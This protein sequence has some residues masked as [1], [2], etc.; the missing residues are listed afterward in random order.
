MTVSMASCT[1]KFLPVFF[2]NDKDILESLFKSC[3]SFSLRFTFLAFYM[4]FN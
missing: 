3:Q 4:C 1:S 2:P